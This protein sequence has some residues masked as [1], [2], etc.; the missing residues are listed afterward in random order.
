MYSLKQAFFCVIK[1]LFF[2]PM[3]IR[4]S[5]RSDAA[6]AVEHWLDKARILEE[7]K[8]KLDR[9][10][11]E[12]RSRFLQLTRNQ[13]WDADLSGSLQHMMGEI[14]WEEY[15][16]AWELLQSINEHAK[17]ELESLADDK[18][19]AEQARDMWT[20]RACYRV[21]SIVKSL[22]QMTSRMTFVNQGGHRYPLIRMDMRNGDLPEKPEDIRLLLREYFVRTIDEL[23]D[24]YPDFGDVP[25]NELEKRMS[26]SQI[27]LTSLKSRY[28]TLHVYKPQTTNV[29]LHESPKKH[30][31]TEWETLNKGSVTEAKGSGGQL[32]AARTIVMMMLM[33]HKRQIRQTKQW[34]VLILDN[35]FGQAVSPHILDPI[36]AIAENLLFQ[37]IVLAPPELIK[38]DVSRRFPVFWELEL[39]RQTHGETVTERLQHGGRTF[40][41]QVDLFGAW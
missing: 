38:L 3:D 16:Y 6:M 14:R 7:A 2:I 28:P 39:K 29:F 33:T 20:D 8:K 19:K 10:V 36:F 11:A 35:P 23:S 15:T 41:G 4:H 21:I 26:D 30:H 18:T 5:V 9:E 24:Q 25:K 27:V 31:Y 37:W 1:F 17:N 13:E 34:S 22:K 12:K 40:E 32:L